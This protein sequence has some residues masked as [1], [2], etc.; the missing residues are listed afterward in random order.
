MI[1]LKIDEKD[2]VVIAS[3]SGALTPE[4]IDAFAAKLNDYVN[5]HDR[6]PNLVLHAESFPHWKN[7][8]ALKQHFALVRDHHKLVKKVAVVS[9]STL[10]WLLRP[11]ADQFTGAKIRRF[12][13]SAFD[14]AVNWAKM[15]EDHPGEF[16][17]IQGLPSDVIGI[18]ARGLITAKD[19]DDVL[20]PLIQSKLKEH[21]ELKLI[22]VAGSYFD[23]YSGGAM[24]DDA[25]LGLMYLRSFSKLA[26]VSDVDWLRKGAK[27]FSP[28]MPADVMVFDLAELD[29]AKKWI[30]T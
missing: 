1:T 30:R 9:D 13:E 2:N 22:F 26:L 29:D 15:D 12:S 24:W 10:I 5:E 16:I 6:V 20:L 4:D 18:D 17:L 19:Y 7:F 3:P 8:D 28:L 11:I 25:K 23:G 14:D 27:L 21:D